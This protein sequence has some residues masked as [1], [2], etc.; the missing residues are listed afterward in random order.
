MTRPR[1]RRIFRL[2]STRVDPAEVDA[3]FESHLAM[4]ARDLEKQG[5]SPD[6]ARAQALA[7]FGDV[8]D[9]RR[10]CQAEDERRM[11]RYRWTQWLESLGQDLSFAARALRRQPAFAVS[12]LVT[13]SVAI[14]LAVTAYGIVHAYLV[15]PLPYPES[16]RLVR[17]LPRA[18]GDRFPDPRFFEQVDWSVADGIFAATASWNPDAFTIA[19]HDRT[20]VV[21]G[22][23]V[24]GSYFTVLGLKPALGR[25]FEPA[26]HVESGPAVI[27]SDALWARLYARDPS[28]LGRAIRVESLE[29]PD[30][31]DL[32]TVVGIMPAGSWHVDRFTDLL[33]PLPLGPQYP[34]MARLKAGMPIAEA[35]RRLNV[36][37]LPQMGSID[38][39]FRYAVV[40]VQQD[41]VERVR[42]T[43]A[44]LLG[45]A[46]FLLLIAGANVAGAQTARS[47]ARRAEMQVRSALGA[48]R[49]RIMFQLLVE[50]LVLATTSGV[51]GAALAGITL[52]AVG[53]AVGERLG[54]A[55]PGGSARLALQPGLLVLMIAIGSLIGAAFGLL[56]AIVLTRA[57]A[58][59]GSADPCWARRRAPRGHRRRRCCGG[60]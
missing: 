29:V 45:G 59:T 41:Y 20:E 55:I 37:V 54:T 34:M 40:G 58:G 32:V 21:R 24:T 14:A 35:E 23:W 2:F 60:G 36:V 53:A 4:R 48:S 10:F 15:R 57:P 11:H 26:E 17:V 1:H 56:P 47:A 5:H 44:A 22:A 28:L 39:S 33:R 9:A 19:G 27:I 6:R 30:R 50:N 46:L 3:E 31:A 13:L 51:I 42:P 7:E 16:D 52:A 12:T 38:S 8:N 25:P 43:L 18:T 49:A